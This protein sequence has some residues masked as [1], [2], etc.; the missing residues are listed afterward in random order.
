MRAI[1]G[2]TGG[3]TWWIE[4]AISETERL[5]QGTA[6]TPDLA[7][8]RDLMGVFDAL[9][10]NTD[11]NSG[12][13]LLTPDGRLHLIDH[14]RSFGQEQEL[15]EGFVEKSARLTHALLAEIESLEVAELRKLLRRH[16][17]KKQI[18]ALLE[19]RDKILAKIAADRAE[20]G[21]DAVLTDWTHLH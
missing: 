9:I 3:L 7:F 11:R 18:E 14:S 20:H 8:Q 10:A 13:Q 1:S 15:P 16:M 6:M 5:N 21:D 19:R 4:D 12:N 17:N 2:D